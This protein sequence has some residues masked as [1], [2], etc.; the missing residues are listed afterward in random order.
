MLVL[1]SALRRINC[2][3]WPAWTSED[4][5]V[6]DGAD[7]GGGPS[8][9]QLLPGK[10]RADSR[11]C[12]PEPAHR[13]LGSRSLRVPCRTWESQ[14]TRPFVLGPDTVA[15][16]TEESAVAERP[17]LATLSAIVHSESQDIAAIL[18]LLARGMRTFDKATATYWAELLEVGLENTPAQETW[19]ELQSMVG[20]GHAHR[21]DLVG[22][23]GQR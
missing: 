4:R 10:S 15:R 3:D 5:F 14:V 22:R 17:A 2:F 23:S 7:H 18:E 8:G 21:G 19:R 16:I 13:I 12:L 9:Q 6:N 11:R 1:R 20:Q